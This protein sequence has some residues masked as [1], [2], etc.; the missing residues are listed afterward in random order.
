MA[1]DNTPGGMEKVKTTRDA[2]KIQPYKAR[3]GPVSNGM[4]KGDRIW[5]ATAGTLSVAFSQKIGGSK[6]KQEKG[7]ASCRRAKDESR[8]GP[9][10][11]LEKF[12]EIF[13]YF[14]QIHWFLIGVRNT[15]QGRRM[16]HGYGFSLV[17]QQNSVG[18]SMGHNKN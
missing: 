12:Q 18:R 15:G 7:S 5:N 13:G 10:F 16:G 17:S 6:S 3:V 9:A 1:G 11:I 8:A 4:E 14:K 2:R